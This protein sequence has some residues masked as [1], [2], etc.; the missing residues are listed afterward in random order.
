[1]IVLIAPSQ[2]SR[3]PPTSTSRRS[4]EKLP[5]MMMAGTPAVFAK[6]GKDIVVGR[7]RH[8]GGWIASIA[9]A[10]A[11]S[12]TIPGPLQCDGRNHLRKIVDKLRNNVAVMGRNRLPTIALFRCD[13]VAVGLQTLNGKR[14]QGSRFSGGR[15]N[16]RRQW[17]QAHP[18]Y[19][20]DRCGALG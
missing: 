19:G 12:P 5:G 10:A 4:G 8:R 13:P 7:R 6:T 16:E 14:P 15:G 17:T 18:A 2:S 3:N 9:A 11:I 1:M 20:R